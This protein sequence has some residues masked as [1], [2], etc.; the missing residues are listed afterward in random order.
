MASGLSARSRSLESNSLLPSLGMS[1]VILHPPS[2]PVVTFETKQIAVPMFCVLS[3]GMVY[4]SHEKV[5][6]RLSLVGRA[7][8]GYLSSNAIFLV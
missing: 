7:L 5:G 6:S 4:L 8:S 1:S 3:F 2:T